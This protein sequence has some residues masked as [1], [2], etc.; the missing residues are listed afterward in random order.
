MP[1]SLSLCT[2]WLVL[3]SELVIP[4]LRIPD[5]RCTGWLRDQRFH[6]HQNLLRYSGR[7]PNAGPDG[8]FTGETP[9][10]HTKY[11]R[12]TGWLLTNGNTNSTNRQDSPPATS[13]YPSQ[14]TT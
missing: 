14:S 3:Q 12:Y 6:R 10:L 5:P 4:K 2:R 9:I 13:K 11:I 1:L 8:I 7:S